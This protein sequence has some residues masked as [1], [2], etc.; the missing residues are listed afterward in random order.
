MKKINIFILL[1]CLMCPI[2]FVA[3]ENSNKN[4]L[5]TPSIAE[6]KA[7]TIVFNPV[8]DAEY[9][10]ISI[11]DNEFY[12][13][14]KHSSYVQ[15]IDNKINYD[16][17]K[18]FIVGESYSVKIQANAEEKNS[19]PFSS[20]Y[21]YKHNGSIQKPTNVKI[22]S[23]TLTWDAVENASYYLVKIVT[24]NDKIILD[25][26]GNNLNLNDPESI[27]KADLTEYSF[28]TNHFDFGSLLTEAGNYQFYVCAVLSNGNNF[29]ESGYTSKTEYIHYIDLKVPTNGKIVKNCFFKIWY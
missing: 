16:A 17:S 15:I 22:N 2:F 10:T 12:V 5:S 13:N 11:N 27:A 8:D 29:V 18:I 9:Y 1:M 23:T 21:S 3:C 7:G 25:K 20:V 14:P 19:S 4:T 28:N 6:I 24:P 26:N